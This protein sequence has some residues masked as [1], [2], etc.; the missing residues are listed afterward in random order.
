[1]LTCLR[2]GSG[3][4]FLALCALAACTAGEARLGD[5]DTDA[6]PDGSTAD[7]TDDAGGGGGGGGGGGSGGDTDDGGS[8]PDVTRKGF[9]PGQALFYADAAYNPESDHLVPFLVGGS[10]NTASLAVRLATASW[11][12]D[13]SLTARYCTFYIYAPGIVARAPWAGSLLF[14]FDFGTDALTYSDC[15][16]RVDPT[17][18]PDL[19][20]RLQDLTWGFAYLPNIYPALAE[21]LVSAGA[22]SPDELAQYIGGGLS[23]QLAR[24]YRPS[25][26]APLG[27]AGGFRVDADFVVQTDAFGQAIPLSQAEITR[28]GDLARAYYSM[29]VLLDW[30]ALDD[31][32]SAP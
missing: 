23:G 16:E 30:P 25:P 6:L 22:A 15:G 8:D 24:P 2:S 12:G 14:G 7:D 20:S 1:M 10:V 28:D 9:V 4:A 29:Q 13:E 11:N 19:V 3:I 27:V 32:L 31:A 18:Y 26:V 5:G 17:A 21:E